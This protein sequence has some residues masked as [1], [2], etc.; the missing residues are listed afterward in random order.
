VHLTEAV[1]GHPGFTGLGDVVVGA[2]DE[3]S[4]TSS[5]INISAGQQLALLIKSAKVSIQLDLSR[6]GMPALDGKATCAPPTRA[7]GS[8][9]T[10][11]PELPVGQLFS[12]NAS[13]RGGVARVRNH[14]PEPL[15]AALDGSIRCTSEVAPTLLRAETGGI[16]DPADRT[17]RH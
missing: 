12:T 6:P 4:T 15:P 16:P 11:F 9:S 10:A 14:I 1:A 8:G 17:G 2:A 3:G 13:I 5:L 7:A